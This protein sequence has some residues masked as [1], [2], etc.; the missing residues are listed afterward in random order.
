MHLQ[1]SEVSE[2]GKECLTNR[3]M[4]TK[5]QSLHVVPYDRRISRLPFRTDMTNLFQK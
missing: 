2:V 3:G 5:D 4:L 1:S